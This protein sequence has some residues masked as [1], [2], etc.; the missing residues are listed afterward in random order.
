MT[1]EELSKLSDEELLAEAKKRKP[2]A[3]MNAI[4]IGFMI[5]I[6]VFSIVKSTVGLF[7]LIPLFFIYKMLNGSKDDEALKQVLKERNLE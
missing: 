5:G 7:T 2:N 3:F 1:A 4:L 6:I